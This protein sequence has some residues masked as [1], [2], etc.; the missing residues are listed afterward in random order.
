M[1]EKA[2]KNFLRYVRINTQSSEASDSA[3]S[4]QNQFDLAKIL[5]EE[6][7]ALGLEDVSLDELRRRIHNYDSRGIARRAEQSFEALFTERDALYRQYADI[8]IDGNGKRHD[9]IIEELL[10]ALERIESRGQRTETRV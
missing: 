10:M 7:T 3:P 4:T 8:V 1:K 9:E 6:L 5:V 2:L